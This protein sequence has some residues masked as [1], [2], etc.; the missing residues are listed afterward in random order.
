M[1]SLSS[2]YVFK[3]KYPTGV[4][5]ISR[6]ISL[7]CGQRYASK[8]TLFI[9]VKCAINTP[10]LIALLIASGVIYYSN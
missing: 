2:D 4:R 9:T 1:K 6:I 3:T 10:R 5:D 8:Y 7:I